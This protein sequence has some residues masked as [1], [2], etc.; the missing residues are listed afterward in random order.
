MSTRN[1]A[2]S[3]YKIQEHATEHNSQAPTTPSPSPR[4]NGRHR[5]TMRCNPLVSAMFQ[6]FEVDDPSVGEVQASFRGLGANV[7]EAA[8]QSMIDYVKA[9]ELGTAQRSTPLRLALLCGSLRRL[10]TAKC[11]AHNLQAHR[12]RPLYW[13]SPQQ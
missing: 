12:C 8:V 10:G 13:E 11:A 3:A 7:D 2:M 5:N 1:L 4:R 9:E 6:V